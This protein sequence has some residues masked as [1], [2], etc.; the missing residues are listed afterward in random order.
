M[1][2]RGSERA[3]GR[4]DLQPPQN[5][6]FKGKFTFDMEIKQNKNKV[7]SYPTDIRYK[8]MQ[9]YILVAFPIL[10]A[11]PTGTITIVVDGE[12]I[13]CSELRY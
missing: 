6:F 5:F 9:D 12:G 13:V 3:G 4:F 2:P 1:Q 7:V 10:S 11:T 8:H